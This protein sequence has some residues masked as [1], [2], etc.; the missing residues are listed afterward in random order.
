MLRRLR[1]LVPTLRARADAAEQGRRVP[2]ESIAELAAAGLFRALVPRRFGGDE[3]ALAEVSSSIIEL[4]QGCSSTAWVASLLATHGFLIAWFDP[5]TQEEV[6]SAGPDVRIASSV[7]PAGTATRSQDGFRLNGT[8]SFVRGV[9]HAQWLILGAVP[10]SEPYTLFLVRASDY[11][12][13]DDWHV[14]GLCGTGSKSVVLREVDVPAHHALALAT[15][16]LHPGQRFHDRSPLYRLPWDPVFRSAFPPVA[17]G[18]A[19]ANLTAFRVYIAAR[20]N[21]FSGRASRFAPGPAMRLAEA[22]ARVDAAVALYRRDNA[23]LDAVGAALDRVLSADAPPRI[24]YDCVFVVDACSEAIHDLWRGSGGKA[25]HR[26]NVLQRHFR[27]MF[28]I[29]QHGAFDV[30]ANAETYGKELIV[31]NRAFGAKA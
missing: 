20:V 8:W 14:A 27:D 23:E 6:W 1:E 31:G 13:E 18:T 5:R 9:E 22:A 21:A 7:A 19:I 25:L 10:P 12:I 11:T 3:R 4:A 24:V 17:I 16:E 15:T 2:D 26:G 30:D 28:A 29:T